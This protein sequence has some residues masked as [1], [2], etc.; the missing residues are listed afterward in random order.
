MKTIEEIKTDIINNSYS[1]EL[2]NGQT[3]HVDKISSRV[4]IIVYIKND[5]SVYGYDKAF[6]VRKGDDKQT[7]IQENGD[8]SM[9]I[10]YPELVN[11]GK[12]EDYYAAEDA[13]TEEIADAIL[14]DARPDKEIM[15][16]VEEG[17]VYEKYKDELD[18][19]KAIDETLYTS[20]L[21]KAY[22]SKW[23]YDEFS[24]EYNRVIR[25]SNDTERLSK[26]RFLED[27]CQIKIMDMLNMHRHDI[28]LLMIKFKKK[29]P[30]EVAEI[31]KAIC[32]KW[33]YVEEYEEWL[34][35]QD[36]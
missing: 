34:D 10:R 23:A 22:Y 6:S 3:I 17:P 21:T 13:L 31:V 18:A 8:F 5:R 7:I 24:E 2:S 20:I 29:H 14:R 9:H 15:A 36:L 1:V 26:T 11:F 25:L 35:D 28:R 32:E 30:E 12:M 16:H 4:A 27:C 19:L 33:D